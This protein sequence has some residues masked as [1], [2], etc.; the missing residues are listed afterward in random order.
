MSDSWNDFP[1]TGWME[2]R[3]MMISS[4]RGRGN[5]CCCSGRWAGMCR[6][7]SR[8]AHWRSTPPFWRSGSLSPDCPVHPPTSGLGDVRRGFEFDVVAFRLPA[9]NDGQGGFIRNEL[10]LQF[11][12]DFRIFLFKKL[13]PSSR[14]SF[15]LAASSRARRSLICLFHRSGKE[16]NPGGSVPKGTFGCQP[17]PGIGRNPC[18]RTRLSTEGTASR[19]KGWNGGGWTA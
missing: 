12:P 9:V 2:T 11:F 1:V 17:T 5:R 4:Y 15:C 10:A 14:I 6:D 18:N 19:K 3:P 16:S 7:R 8:G 13:V